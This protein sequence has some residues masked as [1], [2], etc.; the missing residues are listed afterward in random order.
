M[1]KRRYENWPLLLSGFLRE[2]RDMEFIWGK[3]DCVIFAAD[4]V[5]RLTGFDPAER[6]RGSYSTEKEAVVLL[7]RHGGVTGFV[8]EG[9]GFR[10]TRETL[11]ASRGDVV[12]CKTSWGVMAGI[13]DDSGEKIAVPQ[14]NQK[15]LVRFPL[16][17]AWRVWK[18]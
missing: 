10:G 4:C 5:L 7:R 1:V 18:Y 17:E 14:T 12:V 6:W 2:R 11:T 3:N 9:L 13:V 8:N 15:T 16:S